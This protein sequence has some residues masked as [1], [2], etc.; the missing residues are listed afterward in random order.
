MFWVGF[1]IIVILWLVVKLA[2]WVL[3]S[4]LGILPAPI[5]DDIRR[6]TRFVVAL[7]I[8]FLLLKSCF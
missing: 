1:W 5:P 4:L 8:I 3:N 7:L 6:W 2:M